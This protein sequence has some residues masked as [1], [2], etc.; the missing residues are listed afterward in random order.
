MLHLKMVQPGNKGFAGKDSCQAPGGQQGDWWEVARGTSQGIRRGSRPAGIIFTPTPAIHIHTPFPDSNTSN[1]S[2]S[3]R[4][5]VIF[6]L[7][8]K[9]LLT[10]Q[11]H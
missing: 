3:P 10:V 6:L 2:A 4:T 7:L 11:A 5:P 1:T 9:T 8:Y